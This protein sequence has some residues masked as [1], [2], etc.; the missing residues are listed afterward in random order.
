LRSTGIPASSSIHST[1]KT[2]QLAPSWPE[3]YTDALVDSRNPEPNEVAHDLIAITPSNPNLHWSDI[4]GTDHV[5]MISLTSTSKY[6]DSSLGGPYK[7]ENHYIWV[8]AV[9]EVEAFVRQ[10]RKS[11]GAESDIEPRLR[12][13]LGL[14][15]NA[16]ITKFVEFWVKPE[17]LFRPAPDNEVTDRSASLSLPEDTPSWYREWF[18]D[19]RA[20]QY[21]QS[22]V[23]PHNAYP[24]TQLGYTYD[25][26]DPRSEQGVSE[27]VIKENSTVIVKSITDIGDYGLNVSTNVDSP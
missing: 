16:N 18:N 3:A 24:W 6:Y 14:T 19:L 7:T 23:P 9:P 1:L 8:T 2:L 5:L 25:W 20:S 12:Q 11:H 4:D 26:G 13:L 27:F 15:P 17:D 21:F 10:Y 22:S